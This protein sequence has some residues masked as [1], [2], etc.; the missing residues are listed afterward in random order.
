MMILETGVTGILC[1]LTRE[2]RQK[3]TTQGFAVYRLDL[4]SHVLFAAL[5][6]FR[7]RRRLC[8]PRC[9]G[10]TQKSGI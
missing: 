1:A 9:F 6:N 8:F 7:F 5:G 3:F 4:P 10:Q 2:C